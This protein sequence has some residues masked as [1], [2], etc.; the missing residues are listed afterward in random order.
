MTDMFIQIWFTCGVRRW[1]AEEADGS[2][3]GA[4]GEGIY[5]CVQA[6]DYIEHYVHARNN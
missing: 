6:V 2:D 4:E 5:A 3:F 1:A